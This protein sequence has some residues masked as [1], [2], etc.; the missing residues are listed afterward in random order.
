VFSLLKE[1]RTFA[2]DANRK[3]TPLGVEANRVSLDA[4]VDYAFTSGLIRRRI[5]VDELFDDVT[6]S[7]GA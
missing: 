1:S 3:F 6:R 2:P 7:L 5:A 4:L